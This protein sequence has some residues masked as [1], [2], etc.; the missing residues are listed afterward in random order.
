MQTHYRKVDGTKTKSKAEEA[1]VIDRMRLT[2]EREIAVA[3]SDAT[4]H[5]A[6]DLKKSKRGVM[7]LQHVETQTMP[8]RSSHCTSCTSAIAKE[9][10]CVKQNENRKVKLFSHVG[11]VK[12]NFTELCLSGQAT[13]HL[14][15]VP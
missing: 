5:L 15:R 12:R 2:C 13:V 10:R 6:N 4:V 9:Q 8:F 14:V 7:G 11:D 3:V 1:V